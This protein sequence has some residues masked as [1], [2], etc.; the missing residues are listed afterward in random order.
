MSDK[1][2]SQLSLLYST[3]PTQ[4]EA[5]AASQKLLEQRLIACANILGD[6]QSVYLWKESIENSQEVAV[7]FK[8]T[9]ETIPDL[10]I[11]LQDLHPYDTPAMLEIPLDR[12][13]PSF[14]QWAQA[15]VR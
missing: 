14:I 12:V 9:S 11:A 13:N 10:M 8:T 2:M 7:L 1:Y 5:I 3:F 4:E 15:A 6:I